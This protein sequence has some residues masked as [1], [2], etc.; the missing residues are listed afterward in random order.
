MAQRTKLQFKGAT[1]T[2]G[3][4]VTIVEGLKGDQG[5][6]GPRG[7]RGETGAITLLGYFS[8]LSA[9]ESAVQSPTVGDAYA[10]GE[11]PHQETWAVYVYMLT[12]FNTYD[13]M[14]MG[15]IADAY[16][17]PP[18][19]NF[20]ILGLLDSTDDLPE[21][22]EAGDVYAVGSSSSNTL[23]IWD[24]TLGTP[25]WT[26]IGSLK[27]PKG[28]TGPAGEGPAGGT[29]GQWLT[30][31]SNDEYDF[32]WIEPPIDSEYS[33][34]STNAMSGGAVAEALQTLL[35]VGAVYVSS[36][37]D[38]D[39]ATSP[40]TT[41]GFGTWELIGKDFAETDIK[42][43]DITLTDYFTKTDD[44][45]SE[46]TDFRL[47]RSGRKIRI[48]MKLKVKNK[49]TTNVLASGTTYTMGTFNLSNLGITA[50]ET[51]DVNNIYGTDNYQTLMHMA[52][53]GEV[54]SEVP[55]LQK[56]RSAGSIAKDKLIYVDISPDISM[57]D[58]KTSL[59]NRFYWRR[60]A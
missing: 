10:V 41:I 44:Y 2:D 42:Q 16:Q 50:F 21:S 58:M 51:T 37:K 18:G 11:G 1:V 57:S 19:E 59:C 33:A 46:V 39:T 15:E 52:M 56:T 13:W 4:S 45:V 20:T 26:D 8:S 29:E 36:V 6:P 40:N 12:E 38:G 55:T 14:R 53:I 35:P 27:G 49:A 60:T 43:A 7:P 31:N 47:R 5:N 54:G 48:T 22:G 24:T 28:D 3:G 25:A 9:L 23:Y 30:K 17:G 34:S 32:K